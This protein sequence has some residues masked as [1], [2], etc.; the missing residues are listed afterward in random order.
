MSQVDSVD[1]FVQRYLKSQNI[2]QEQVEDKKEAVESPAVGQTEPASTTDSVDDFV[3]RYLKQSGTEPKK[4][5]AE[6]TAA[7]EPSEFTIDQISGA[8]GEEPFDVVSTLDFKRTIGEPTAFQQAGDFVGNVGDVVGNILAN[9]FTKEN[10][11]K[12]MAA[13]SEG[14]REAQIG[15]GKIG[16]SAALGVAQTPVE[17]AELVINL[18]DKDLVKEIE[19]SDFGKGYSQFLNAIEPDLT[20][21]QKMAADILQYVGG[22]TAFAKVGKEA[23]ALL[24]NKFGKDRV[25]KIA[26]KME[27]QVSVPEMVAGAGKKTSIGQKIAKVGSGTVGSIATGVELL[28]EEEETIGTLLAENP[29]IIEDTFG[30]GLITDALIAAAEAV[31][32]N[33]DDSEARQQIQKFKEEALIQAP[34]IALPPLILFGAKFY[35]QGGKQAIKDIGAVAKSEPVT[36]RAKVIGEGIAK[37]TDPIRSGGKVVIESTGLDTPIKKV[38]EQVAK[39]NT[40]AGRFFRSD[41]A[42]PKE[43]ARSATERKTSVAAAEFDTKVLLKDLKELQQ[44]EGISDEAFEAYFNTGKG[45]VTDAFKAEFNKI[46]RLINQNERKINQGLGLKGDA[47]LAIRSDGQDFYVTRTFRANT[48]PEYLSTVISALKGKGKKVVPYLPGRGQIPTKLMEAIKNARKEFRANGF[49][50]ATDNEIDRQILIMVQNVGKK[51]DDGILANLFSGTSLGANKL[52]VESAKVLR[53]RKNLTE[54]VLEILGKQTNPYKNLQNTLVNQSRLLSEIKYFKDI[55]NF[56]IKNL[57]KKI[58]LPGLIPMLPSKKVVVEGPTGTAFKASGDDVAKLES[59]A[60][61]SI[62]K[63]GG[64]SSKIL[65]SLFSDKKFATMLR[66][67]IDAFNP[68]QRSNIMQWFSKASSLVQAKETLFDLPAY[69]LNTQ[70]VMSSLL[71][72]GQFFNPKNYKRAIKEIDTLFQQVKLDKPEAIAKLSMLKRLGVIDQDV[73]GAMIEANAKAF[74]GLLR[75]GNESAYTKTM[76]KFGRAYGQPDL[77]GKLVAFEAEAA[78]LR[79]MFPRDKSRFPK[80]ADYD[81]FINEEAA[82]VV[83]DTMPTY[84]VAAPAAREFARVPFVGNYIL[85]PSE[86]FRTTKNMFKYGA[87]D[88]MQGIANG[89]ERQIATGMR[90]LT[91]L[92]TVMVGYDQAINLNNKLLGVDDDAEKAHGL[93]GA[94]FQKGSRTLFMEMPV[95]DET[96]IEKLTLDSVREQF[97]REE[98]TKIKS[99]KDYDGTYNQFIKE[100][101]EQQRN[102]FRPYVKARTMNSTTFGMYDS[103]Q[104]P[105]R[106]AMAK[107]IGSGTISNEEIDNAWQNAAS[108]ITSPYTSPKALTEAVIAMATGRDRKTGKSIWDEAVGATTEDQLKSL[109]DNV[110]IKQLLGGTG[111]VIRDYITADNAEELLGAGN[112]LRKSGFPV[113]KEDIRTKVLT[114]SGSET[115]NVNKRMGFDLSERLKPIAATKVNYQNKLRNLDFKLQNR[116][117]VDNIVEEYKSLQQR[118]REGMRDFTNRVSVYKNYPYIRIYR[119]KD[120]KVKQEKELFGTEGVLAAATDDFWFRP[121]ETLLKTAATEIA[122]EIDADGDLD[123]DSLSTDIPVVQFFPDYPLGTPDEKSFYINLIRKGFRED[124]ANEL[125]GKLVAVYEK[126]TE[127]PLFEDVD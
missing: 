60:K 61:E 107:L 1:E 67:G 5:V 86:L 71:G 25:R 22:Y 11:S 56:A 109:M 89:N 57:N 3:E 114:G 101:L 96:A 68:L 77:Y 26:K 112:A 15:A 127:I 31:R 105:F 52:G 42:L 83:R 103:I 98:W 46:K 39:I 37:V 116:E 30:K 36:K 28:P 44:K 102:N 65:Q 100:T 92:S 72:N 55:E 93:F 95:K 78:A 16:A 110:V 41:A 123:V 94:P 118:K 58:K 82:Q 40:G 63:F 29:E 21:D 90:R 64:D 115:N 54:P 45:D 85:F 113:T 111:K 53:R 106:L 51:T 87:R 4:Q 20:D 34:L 79:R 120:G 10:I 91:G 2:Q 12:S 49:K 9:A 81:K 122:E 13:V 7:P 70:G 32:I 66:D 19:E 104:S 50:D 108:I 121:D 18:A 117:D 6:P 62:G 59:I 38:T 97:P 8:T 84:G 47:K 76:Q 124:L 43:I 69:V 99:D 73:T 24:V 119:D 88:V 23:F 74:T 35:G 27:E 75:S 33:P 125:I 80:K 17:L 14:Q 126:E 48:D